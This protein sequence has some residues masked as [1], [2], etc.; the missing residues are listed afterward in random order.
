MACPSN[1]TKVFLNYISFLGNGCYHVI[2]Y[3]TEDAETYYKADWNFTIG[4]KN[5]PQKDR[6]S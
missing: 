3:P 1:L 6:A 4:N 2:N 5:M